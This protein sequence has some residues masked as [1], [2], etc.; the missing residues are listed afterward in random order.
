MSKK[1]YVFH[2]LSGHENKVKVNLER[3][4]STLKLD[5]K[6]GQVLIPI[7]EVVE[8][9]EEHEVPMLGFK[10]GELYALAVMK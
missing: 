3:M 8:F 4:V 7:E 10:E 6:I 2:T 5:D 1:W 9:G